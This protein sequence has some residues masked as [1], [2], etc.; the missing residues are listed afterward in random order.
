LVSKLCSEMLV[1]AYSHLF[2]TVILRYFFVYGAGQRRSMLIPRLV[3]RVKSGEPI[4]LQGADGIRINPTYV[5][6]AVAATARAV[7][8][9][10]RHT[11]NVAGPETLTLRD[12]G[13]LIGKAVGREPRFSV[14]DGKPG[15]LVADIARMRE[16]LGAPKTGFADGLRRTL[17]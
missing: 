15:H 5:G 2:E 10:G 9:A 14:S 8:I 11:I 13:T 6:D 17:E 12:V 4:A 7:Q 3:D 1:Q 16:L